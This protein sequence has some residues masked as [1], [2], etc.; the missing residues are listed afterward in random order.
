MTK[1]ASRR[2]GGRPDKRSDVTRA[3]RAVF[4]RLGYAQAS[5]DVIAAE[6]A[7]STRT[8]YQHF[9]TKEELFAAVLEDSA[10]EVADDFAATVDSA[11]TGV[12][13]HEDLIALGAAFVAQ[14]TD[15][16]EHFA[17]VRQIRADALQLPSEVID[18]WHQ[19]GPL[20]VQTKVADRLRALA[21][22]G[23]LHLDSAELAALHFIAL[24]TA[25]TTIRPYAAATPHPRETVA[26]VKAGVTAFL[27]GYGT[28]PAPA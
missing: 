7:V 3:A 2:A 27:T 25:P 12:D 9:R 21:D 11:M 10:H 15:H 16:P 1:T 23:Q 26:A 22:L 17:M 6:A 20:R 13:V 5:M 18:R 28:S 19:A 24:V 8:I 4:G 14:T